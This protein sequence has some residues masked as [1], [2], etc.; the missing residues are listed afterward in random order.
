MKPSE[1]TPLT[2]LALCDLA[3]DAGFPAG[4]IQT[5]PGLG[6]TTGAAIAAHMDIDKV[7]Q[8]LPRA[9]APEGNE[10]IVSVRGRGLV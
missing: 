6:A 10:L 3:L 8:G 1:L 4:V 2:A 7:R 9:R 5:L